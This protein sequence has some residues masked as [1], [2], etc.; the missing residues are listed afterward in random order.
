MVDTFGG[1]MDNYLYLAEV[2]FPTGEPY[3]VIYREGNEFYIVQKFNNYKKAD[4]K[5]EIIRTYRVLPA[6]TMERVL[7]EEDIQKIFKTRK[8]AIST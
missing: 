6:R 5:F 1:K 3:G 8:N 4:K 2:N 7:R